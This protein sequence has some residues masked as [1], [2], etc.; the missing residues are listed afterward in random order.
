[1]AVF[2]GEAKTLPPEKGNRLQ[3][4][5]R[6]SFRREIEPIDLLPG[7][8]KALKGQ[9]PSV[10]AIFHLVDGNSTD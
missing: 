10:G 3:S 9:T 6:S 4:V 2:G 8:L 7:V 5:N 1:M